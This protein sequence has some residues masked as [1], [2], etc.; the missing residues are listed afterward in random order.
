MPKLAIALAALTGGKMMPRM[1]A[2]VARM[3]SMKKCASPKGNLGSVE[4]KK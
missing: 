3:A 2:K 4:G 1:V